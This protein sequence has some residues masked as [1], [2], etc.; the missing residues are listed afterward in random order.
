MVYFLFGESSSE[1]YHQ[2]HGSDITSEEM[3]F[4][5]NENF[6]YQIFMYDTD[7]N[8]PSDILFEYDGWNGFAEIE[9]DLYELLN[10]KT[11]P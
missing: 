5:I 6:D 11:K 4:H 1:Y 8:H 3:A 2:Y 7:Y 9:E 10:L